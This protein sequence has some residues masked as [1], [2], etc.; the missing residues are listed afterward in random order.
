MAPDEPFSLH[1]MTPEEAIRKMFATPEPKT[2]H[3]ENCGDQVVTG[4]AVID[5]EGNTR[6]PK[7]GRIAS[8]ERNQS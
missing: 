7:C 5:D 8:H 6:C 3:C 4:L 2:V 1:G